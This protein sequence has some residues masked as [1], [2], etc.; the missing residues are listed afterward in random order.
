M[1]IS[2]TPTVLQTGTPFIAQNLKGA[3]AQNI[4][5]IAY[6]GDVAL[7]DEYVFGYA[8]WVALGPNKGMIPV[9]AT[10]PAASSIFGVV[11]NENTGVMDVQGY[12]QRNGFYTNI[13]V[14]KKGMIW[15]E[16][17]GTVDL[18]STL[19]LYIDATDTTN[20]NK[21][22]NGSASGAIDISSIAS[23]AKVSN[24]SNLVLINID[25]L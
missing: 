6:D 9:A 23:V 13:P 11:P 2:I 10:T 4:R 7:A 14:L 25:I 16:S 20:Y 5:Q 15:V 21:V 1:S 24:S 3:V 17:T 8:Q 12:Q 19:Y 22:R 18:D